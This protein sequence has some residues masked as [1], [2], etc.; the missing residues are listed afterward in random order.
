MRLEPATPQSRAKH[1]TTE[2]LVDVDDK[3]SF[4]GQ[5]QQD[6]HQKQ[7]VPLPFPGET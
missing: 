1:S 7:H 5:H 2:L 4:K 3:D 6:P